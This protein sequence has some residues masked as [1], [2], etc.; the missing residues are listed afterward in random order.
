MLNNKNLLIFGK[1]GGVNWGDEAI[2]EGLLEGLTGLCSVNKDNIV[3]VSADPDFTKNN[4]RV[5][6]VYHLPFGLR[7]FFGFRFLKTIKAI[8]KADIILFGGGGLF[9]D[10]EKRAFLMWAFFLRVCLFFKKKVILVANS[11]GPLFSKKYKSMASKLFAR[12]DFFSVRD[13][14]SKDFLINLDVDEKKII[15]CCD[16]VFLLDLKKW[17]KKFLCCND[18]GSNDR[19]FPLKKFFKISKNLG[20]L[21]ALHGE[22]TSET[23]LGEISDFLLKLKKDSIY[24]SFLPMQSVGVHDFDLAKDLGLFCY[25]VN[26]LLEVKRIIARSEVVI[27]SRLHAIILAM[28]SG[29]PFIAFSKMDKVKNFLVSVGLEDFFID[30]VSKDILL[31]KL[32]FIYDNLEEVKKR[33]LE[34]VLRERE[35]RGKVFEGIL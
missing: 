17:N 13:D 6:S 31:E 11:V 22:H 34:A 2:L 1:Y 18:F 27:S 5:K 7:S 21:F 19:K 30:V 16:A 14:Q 35:K 28:L 25:P 29:V 10:K 8:I 33:I 24:P 12:V 23:E 9:Q 32:N 20:L 4:F 3:V 15:R 26:S